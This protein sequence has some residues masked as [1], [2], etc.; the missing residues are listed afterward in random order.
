MQNNA[1]SR[2]LAP[3]MAFCLS[4][5]IIATLATITGVQFERQIDF[6]L[7]WLVTMFILALP[8]CYLEIALA[9]RSKISALQ[10]LSHLTRE[11]EA[12]QK[13]RIVAWL[14]VV[15]IPFLAGSMLHNIS[16]LLIQYSLHDVSTSILLVILA[17][18]SILL[19]FVPRQILVIVS[20]IAIF[21]SILFANLFNTAL[22]TWSMTSIEFKEWGNATILALVASGLG[23]GLYWQSSLIHVDAQ[24]NTTR[25]VLAIWIAQLLAMIA[26]GFFILQNKV[27]AY[28]FI[29]A[30]LMAAALLLQMAREQLVQRQISPIL[31]WAIVLVA[32]LVWA[33][34]H[35]DQFFDH[36]LVI[37]GLL[38]C[39]MYAIFAGWIMKISHLR[40]SINFSN[41]AVYN[42]WR[43]A[44]RIVL[45]LGIIFALIAYLGQLI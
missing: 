9:K 1:A 29:F 14:A 39:L 45:P 37:W 24:P 30:I 44:V 43:I 5:L 23:L 12:S 16:G 32:L 10:A 18:L 2:W 11:A 21:A 13:W 19:S 33:I 17:V 31:Q 36:A 35:I 34:P 4:F 27:S 38:I 42:I 8:I 25:T 15:F 26:F 28:A 7:L 6:W 22:P 3:L 20:T 40:K 41:E